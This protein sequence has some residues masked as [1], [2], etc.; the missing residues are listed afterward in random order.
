MCEKFCFHQSTFCR[1]A[2]F[3]TIVGWIQSG[4]CDVSVHWTA[5]TQYCGWGV[6][7]QAGWVGHYVRLFARYCATE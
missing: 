7:A 5:A 4:R 3:S 2:I 1:A 6:R